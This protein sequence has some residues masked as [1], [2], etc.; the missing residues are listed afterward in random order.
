MI[1]III[2]VI[3][4][5]V[6]YFCSYLSV[7]DFYGYIHI[8]WIVP[9]SV[10]GMIA[11]N[12]VVA[13]ICSKLIP[14]KWFDGDQKFYMPSKKECVFY[15]KIGIKKWKD[16]T[17]ELGMLNGFRKNKLDEPNNEAYLKRFILEIKKGYLTHFISSFVSVLSIFLWPKKCLLPMALPISI[18]SLILNIIPMIILRYNMPRLKTLL[19]F[20]QR[21]KHTQL[22]SALVED[23]EIKG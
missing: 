16:H 18:T 9:V 5:I 1:S 21:K 22:Q 8:T 4:V 3:G 20:C 12:G 10:I 13:I 2:F 6:T 14:N 11:I 17:L 23:V 7:G 15:E 19:K